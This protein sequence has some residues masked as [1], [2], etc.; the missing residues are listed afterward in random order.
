MQS[1]ESATY[2]QDFTK[3][4]DVLLEIEDVSTHKP[5]GI[6]LDLGLCTQKTK[7]MLVV[8]LMLAV[9]PFGYFG[10]QMKMLHTMDLM[11]PAG[12]EPYTAYLDLQNTFGASNLFISS[13]LI[14]PKDDTS[15]MSQEFFDRSAGYIQSLKHQLNGTKYQDTVFEGAM[16]SCLAGKALELANTVGVPDR[17]STGCAIEFNAINWSLH[18]S[19]PKQDRDV[20]DL[21]ANVFDLTNFTAL[22]A[23]GAQGMTGGFINGTAKAASLAVTVPKGID[24]MSAEG[25]DWIEFMRAA[26]EKIP[27]QHKDNIYLAKGDILMHDSIDIVYRLFPYVLAG[28]LGVVFAMVGFCFCSVLVPL[29]SV[30]TIA[31]TLAWVYGSAILIYQVGILDF[32]GIRSIHSCEGLCWFAPVMSCSVI[33]G[34]GLDY[35]IFLL[36]RVLELRKSGLTETGSVV[37][38]LVLTGHIITAAGIIMAIAFSGLLLSKELVMN[39]LAFLLVLSV[40]I[41]TFLVRSVLVPAIMG[42]L[43][44]ANWWPQNQCCKMQRENLREPYD[45]KFLAK[46]YCCCKCCHGNKYK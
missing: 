7:W 43:G 1:A 17:L 16:W 38:G 4:K 23:R 6:W 21:L 39:Q 26:I 2:E 14:V 37:K 33:I 42:I 29:R 10:V 30:V 28:T 25:G 27:D 34:V 24:V 18:D 12:S 5:R 44:C 15:V 8:L 35:D 19:W 31:M 9:L 36:T 11:A 13:L 46:H 32:L 45:E 41:D 20:I 40:L 3:L 22:L